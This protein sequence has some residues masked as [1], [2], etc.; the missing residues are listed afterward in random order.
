M[1]L[2]SVQEILEATEGILLKSNAP[3][4][5]NDIVTDSRQAN[6]KN[7]FIALVGE[8]LNGHNFANLAYENGCRTFIK[9]KG[10]ILNGLEGPGSSND[11]HIIEVNNTEIALGD[12]A[13]FYRDKFDDI[14]FIGITGSV[15]KTTTRDMVYSVVSSKFNTLKNEKNFNNQIGV[16]L[17]LF[18]LNYKHECAVV[19]M[20]MS[21]F[22]E[23]EYL[24]DIVRPNIGVISNIGQSHI[25]KLGS[26]LGI[27]KAKMEITKNFNEN[28]TLIVNGDDHCLKI[29][30]NNL[31]QY[32]IKTFGFSN[33]C[34]IYCKAFKADTNK[35]EFTCVIDN[36]EYDFI[37]PIVGEHNIYNAMAAILVGITLGI[38]IEKI[39]QGLSSLK[40]TGMRLEI[41]ETEKFTIINDTY[42]ASPDSMKAALKVLSTYNGRRVAVLGDMFEMGNYTISGHQSVGNNV[43]NNTDILITIGEFSKN[44]S[45]EAIKNG[46]NKENVLHFNSKEECNLSNLLNDKDIILFKASRGMAFETLIDSIR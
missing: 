11:I 34:S 1:D 2:F 39:K 38:S 18:N 35:T 23:I 27:F 20:G 6:K 3:L 19:E 8:N 43:L 33:K 32:T 14:P 17:T 4:Y 40:V 16:P 21:G 7:A 45:D 9:Q 46:F 29:L 28:S 37:I 30:N 31:T 22:N 15:G 24:A 5:I 25:E 36:K 13:K 41:E 26:T 44:I 12:I 42:N 10:N